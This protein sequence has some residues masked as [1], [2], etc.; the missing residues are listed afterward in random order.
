VIK[1]RS[2]LSAKTSRQLPV[3]PCNGNESEPREGVRTPTMRESLESR[4]IDE[5]FAIG[6]PVGIGP[7]IILLS[8]RSENYRGVWRQVL[9][10]LQAV[11]ASAMNCL[12]IY[13]RRRS[14][15]TEGFI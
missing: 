14:N 13:G 7:C 11:D 4:P 3:G 8:N 5:I 12:G 15:S 1:T 2:P 6:W 10:T 9:A